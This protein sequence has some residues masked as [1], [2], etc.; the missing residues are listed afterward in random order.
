MARLQRAIKYSWEQASPSRE[1]R[2]HLIRIYEDREDYLAQY[3]NDFKACNAYVNL[4]AQYVRGL[5][6]SL[7]YNIPR[8]LVE[9]RQAEGVGFDL[10][11]KLMLDFYSPLVGLKELLRSWA[12]DCAF[13]DA[14]ARI[15]E[16]I[17]P[18]GVYAPVAPRVYRVPPNNLIKDWSADTLETSCFIAELY[19]VPLKDAR[20]FPGFDPYLRQ[21]ISEYRFD[22]DNTRSAYYSSNDAF[23]ESQARLL[24]VYLPGTG[25]ILTFDCPDDSFSRVSAEAL[26]MTASPI[27]PYELC[28][29]MTRPDSIEELARLMFLKENHLLANDMIAKAATQARQSKRNPIGKIGDELDLAQLLDAP[30]GEAAFLTDK[31]N[32]DLYTLPGPDPS[33]V[34]LGRMAQELFSEQAGNTEV[35][36]GISPGARTA[37]QSQAMLQQAQTASAYD[38]MIFDGFVAGIGKKLATL[39]FKSEVFEFNA[40][41]KVPGTQFSY[42]VHWGPDSVVPRVGEISDYNFDI[43]PYSNMFRPP[44][45]KLAQLQQASQSIMMW[46]QA[47]AQGAPVN[48]EYIMKE[49]A[50]AFDLLTCLPEWWSGE[51]PTPVQ[52][53]ANTYQSMAQPS[54][55][56]D[57]RYEGAFNTGGGAEYGGEP[58]QGG[59]ANGA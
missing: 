54:Q 12:M 58:S 19:L 55:G 35:Q 25:A 30:D 46:M 22:T 26:G 2:N 6:L 5:Q 50:E 41:Q 59:F 43:V 47:A 11:M 39:A 36:L 13:G 7:G 4:F 38:R 9:A 32:I 24:D 44:A 17:S 42:N 48:L 16:G 53:T 31:T 10:R 34:S 27:N 33:I 56:S 52:Q 40:V 14:V 21:M 29:L 28:R 20:A 49:H 37:R 15:S 8:W 45:E 1:R 23:A 57:I 51:K 18:K 3:I